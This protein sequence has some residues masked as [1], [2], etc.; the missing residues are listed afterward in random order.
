MN[1][2]KGKFQW[3]LDGTD[4]LLDVGCG[5]GDVTVDF[6][7]P[8]MP[9]NFHRLVGIDLSNDMIEYANTNFK[10]ENVKFDVFDLEIDL[11]NQSFYK[12]GQFDHIISFNCIHWVNNQETCMQSLYN[13]LKPDGDMLLVVGAEISIYETYLELSKQIKWKKYLYDAKRYISPY[14]CG[15][16]DPTKKFESLLST[17]NFSNYSI[18]VREESVLYDGPDNFKSN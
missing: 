15:L 10:R 14:R 12:A 5:S 3:Q 13:L 7:L 16:D 17:F 18:E 9:A 1:E 11:K 2:F 8:A 6:I 4:S